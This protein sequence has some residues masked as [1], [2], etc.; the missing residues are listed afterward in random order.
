MAILSGVCNQVSS[1][2]LNAPVSGLMGLGWQAL[3]SSGATPFWQALYEDNVLDEP[4]M[5][6]YLTRFQNASKSQAQEPGGV[7]TI[8]LFKATYIQISELIVSSRQARPTLLFI[9]VISTIKISPRAPS[10]I[11]LSPSR[12]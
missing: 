8:G 6:F 2:L 5:A 7:F 1:G 4:L 11:G 3:A 12:A 9:R 10:R